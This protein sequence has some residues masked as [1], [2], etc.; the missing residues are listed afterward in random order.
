MVHIL[1]SYPKKSLSSPGEVLLAFYISLQ[2][3]FWGRR[4]V[5]E[6]VLCNIV[7]HDKEKIGQ[8]VGGEITS[9]EPLP[10]GKEKLE[11]KD[12]ESDTKSK[13][14]NVII[15]ASVGGGL[16]LVLIAAVLIWCHRYLT[17]GKT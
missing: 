10:C 11:D 2:Q 5:A 8:S 6:D 14:T 17:K 12:E 15:G 13:P 16:L 4:F 9:A 3:G 1:P 7:M